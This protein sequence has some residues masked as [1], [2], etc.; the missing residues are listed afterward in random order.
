[1]KPL[2]ITAHLLVA[3][4]FIVLL[5]LTPHLP[6][7]L[8]DELVTPQS[9]VQAKVK[10][11]THVISTATLTEE[12]NCSATAIARHAL[13]TA[14]HCEAPSDYVSIDGVPGYRIDGVIRDNN[15]HSILLIR[16]IEFKDFIPLGSRELRDSEP[17][18]IWGNPSLNGAIF[19]RQL[20]Q[21]KYRGS[22]VIKGRLVDVLG[23]QSYHGDSGSGVFTSAGELLGVV[24]FIGSV[25]TPPEG[26]IA[27]ATG[28]V[29]LAF[30]TADKDKAANFK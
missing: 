12:A 29:R 16:G 1:M 7:L 4:L 19:I 18:F 11:A 30:T 20:H 8:G 6:R 17:V 22:H 25:A 28:A 14:S 23:F 21:G 26:I 5:A 3:A 10:P 2:N 13:L 24:S 9:L 27:A 15:D